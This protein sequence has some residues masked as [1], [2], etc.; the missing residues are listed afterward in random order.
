MTNGDGEIRNFDIVGANLEVANVGTVSRYVSMCR[1]MAGVY[2]CVGRYVRAAR[3]YSRA[4][5]YFPSP[6]LLENGL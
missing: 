3:C 2:S 1:C 5:G 6:R 4:S